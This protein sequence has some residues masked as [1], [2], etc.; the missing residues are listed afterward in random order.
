MKKVA[1]VGVGA[2]GSNLVQI[3]RGFDVEVRVVDFDRVEAKNLRSQFHVKPQVGKQKVDAVK[4]TMSL[5]W[6]TKVEA[7]AGRLGTGSL[8]M[9]TGSELLVDCVDNAETRN[10]IISYAAENKV[11]CVH[12]ALA[13]NGEFGRVAWDPDFKVD[14]EG[15]AGQAT[16]DDGN[17]LPFIVN[18]SSYLAM[19]IQEWLK[20]GRKHNYSI[21]PT[22]SFVY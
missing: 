2:L 17:H 9:L 18:V 21:S 6:G 15:V 19:S 4:A 10:L 12:G 8:G 16:C 22:K 1:V 7:K 13:A 11:P 20:T 14:S 3:M 5:L